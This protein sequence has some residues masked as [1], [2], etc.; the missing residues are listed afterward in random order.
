MATAGPAAPSRTH[1]WSLAGHRRVPRTLHPVAWWIWA[2]GLATAAS[3]TTNPLLLLLV[4]AVLG[5]VVANRRSEAPWARAFKYY[6]YL[7]LIVVVI[8]VVFRVGVRRRHRR[9]DDARALHAAA[10]PAAVVD[11]RG[12]ARWPGHAG[13]HGRPPSTTACA[14]AACSAASARR[15]RWPTRSG[16]C[17]VL[18]G[19]LYELGVAVVV[20]LTVAPQLVES[21]QR[22]RRARRLRGGTDGRS[23]RAAQ[24]RHPGAGGRPRTFAA[25]GRGDG[26]AGLRPHRYGHPSVRGGS[27]AS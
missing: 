4:L 25:A 5:I 19:A 22:V 27:P 2:I 26:L 24:H 7:A 6:L 9:D 13:G 14:S 1:R 15:T 18:P 11:G 12:P 20:A 21:V 23:P 10:R 17:R 3:R 16:R 8:R